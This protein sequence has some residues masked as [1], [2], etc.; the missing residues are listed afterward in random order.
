VF[1][2]VDLDGAYDVVSSQEQHGEQVTVF[3]GPTNKSQLL[4]PEAWKESKFKTVFGRVHVDVRAA[5]PFET[6]PSD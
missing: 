5:H 6:G 2:D 3:W 1:A 4:Q